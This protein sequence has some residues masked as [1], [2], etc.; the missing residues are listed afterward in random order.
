MLRYMVEQCGAEKLL[1]GTDFPICNI[2]MQ[3]YGVLSEKISEEAKA[4]I[5][6]GNYDRLSGRS[7]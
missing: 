7:R 4:A 6:S 5:F 1:F 3:V 2:S